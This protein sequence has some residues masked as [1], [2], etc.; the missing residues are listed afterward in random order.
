M[1]TNTIIQLHKI[2]VEYLNQQ[3]GIFIGTN[4]VSDWS[5]TTKTNIGFA[6]VTDAIIVGCTSVVMDDD[7]VDLLSKNVHKRTFRKARKGQEFIT[8]IFM[9]KIDV[10]ALN[11][12]TIAVGLN[13]QDQ[14][15]SQSKQNMG[16]GVMAGRSI[17][18]QNIHTVRDQDILDTTNVDA[19]RTKAHLR[20][21]F[22]KTSHQ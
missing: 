1:T 13:E 6:N 11:A 5:C 2:D 20:A 18:T 4:I 21:H 16:N 10:H 14:W 19:Y 17:L 3:S 22:Q 15:F 7:F 8:N 9:P 12:S